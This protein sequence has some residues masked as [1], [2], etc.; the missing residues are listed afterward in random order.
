VG[1]TGRQLGEATSSSERH[2]GLIADGDTGAPDPPT[3]S[4]RAVVEV[5]GRSPTLVLFGAT[6]EQVT[7]CLALGDDIVLVQAHDQLTDHQAK[8]AAVV[9]ICDIGTRSNVDWAVTQLTPYGHLP[10]VSARQYGVLFRALVAERL[11]QDPLSSLRC[12]ET[13]SDK[14][15]LRRRIDE[16][17]LPAPAWRVIR[18]EPDIRQFC[19]E[20][21][22]CGVLKLARGTG[23]VGVCR[24]SKDRPVDLGMLRSRVAEVLP[25]GIGGAGFL[26]EEHLE[27]QLFSVESVWVRGVHVPLGITTSEVSTTSTAELRHTFPGSLDGETVRDATGQ[28]ERLFGSLGMYSGGTHV[29]FILV[30][31][32]PTMIDAHDRPGGGHIPEL[33][34]L[35]VGHSSTYLAIA[36]QAGR[37]TLE[38]ALCLRTTRTAV[39]RFVTFPAAV[40]VPDRAALRHALAELNQMTEVEAAHVDDA[41]ELPG[42][43]DNWTRPGHVV[44]VADTAEAAERAADA[45]HAQIVTTLTGR[46]HG[47][48]PNC[49]GSQE[50]STE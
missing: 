21:E 18:A 11:G 9:V 24:V 5:D 34:Q 28:V 25:G 19:D 38:D 27:G 23:G 20:H 44:T 40:A 12:S 10:F 46:D 14:T 6:D 3:R 50:R 41:A 42:E 7:Q 37:L 17:G 15:A 47:R 33:V 16:L 8:A 29:E 35:T 30:G 4:L 31:G 43:V 26:V 32:V 45:A 22:G 13:V 1:S 49:G 2:V 36:A 48:A 39:V